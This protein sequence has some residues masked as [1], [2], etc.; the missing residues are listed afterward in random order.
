LGAAIANQFARKAKAWPDEAEVESGGLFGSD[1]GVAGCEDGGF[2]DVVVN[3]DSDRIEGVGDGKARDEVHRDRGKQGCVK[4]RS[5]RVE[6]NGGAI[7]K[8]LGSLKNGATVN[9]VE[10]RGTE[11]RPPI[12]ACDGVKGLETT[13]MTHSRRVVGIGDDIAAKLLVNWDVDPTFVMKKSFLYGP[14]LG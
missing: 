11:F 2:R 10:D 7:G 6:G 13:G 5:D 12:L 4:F 14:L 3:E 8:V 9:E 1:G